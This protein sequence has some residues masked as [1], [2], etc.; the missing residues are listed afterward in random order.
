MNLCAGLQRVPAGTSGACRRS[1]GTTFEI[2]LFSPTSAGAVCVIRRSHGPAWPV[3]ARSH[4]LRGIWWVYRDGWRWSEEY[5]RKVASDE[6][7]WCII[8]I[9]DGLYIGTAMRKLPNDHWSQR[10][11]LDG[12]CLPDERF[13]YSGSAGIGTCG[14]GLYT[15][16]LYSRSGCHGSDHLSHRGSVTHHSPAVHPG[17]SR[18]PLRY[19]ELRP[20]R[21]LTAKLWQ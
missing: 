17:L 20:H 15:S 3:S 9:N 21:Q 13:G 19:D 4:T 2:R 5:L 16:C 14:S 1:A 10:I 11:V 6:E 12:C 18:R 8:A 7:T